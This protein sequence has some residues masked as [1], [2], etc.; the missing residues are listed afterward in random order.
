[1]KK[2]YFLDEEE[3]NRILNL[4]ESRTKKQY[5]IKEQSIGSAVYNVAGSASQ[6]AMMGAYLGTP[7]IVAGAVIGGA[8][9]LITSIS[10]SMSRES[11]ISTVTQICSSGGKPTLA[12]GGLIDIAEKLNGLINTQNYLG[13]GYATTDSRAKIKQTLSTIPSIPDLCG[14]MK[15]YK[16]LYQIDLLS[17]LKREIYYDKYWNETV[18]VPLTKAIKISKEAT[19]K[20]KQSQGQTGGSTATVPDNW[21]S[22]PCVPKSEGV[23]PVK[24]IEGKTIIS[25]KRYS[26]SKGKYITYQ[27]DGTYWWEGMV[28]RRRYKCGDNGNGI[29]DAEDYSSLDKK[30]TSTAGGGGGGTGTGGGDLTSRVKEIQSKLQQTTEIKIGNS[31]QMDQATINALMAKLNSLGGKPEAPKNITPQTNVQ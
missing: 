14:V 2:L 6:G 8:I 18:M 10:S 5:L 16:D 28:E 11:F 23:T 21:K 13:G 26:Q 17:D 3:K 15:E 25:Y 20:S 9:G 1:M 22:Y 24:D 31:G 7:G 27:P 29:F 19:E 4:H 12:V 30:Q